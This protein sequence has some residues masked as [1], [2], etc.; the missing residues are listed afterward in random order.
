MAKTQIL[1]YYIH[2]RDPEVAA[3]LQAQLDAQ[4]GPGQLL[5]LPTGGVAIYRAPDGA[6]IEFAIADGS[7]P[8]ALSEVSVGSAVPATGGYITSPWFTSSN[9]FPRDVATFTRSSGWWLFGSTTRFY[10]AGHIVYDPPTASAG[11]D[12]GVEPTERENVRFG[13]QSRLFL[14]GFS[15]PPGG[16]VSGTTATG[17]GT[18]LQTTPGAGRTGQGYG[19]RC[20][21]GAGAVL[22]DTIGSAQ[23]G[24]GKT[25]LWQRIYIRPKTWGTATHIFWR[26]EQASVANTGFALGIALD[27][28]FAL[29][30]AESGS[31]NLVGTFGQTTIDAW[32]R[33]DIFQYIDQAGN[34]QYIDVD[35]NGVS[36]ISSSRAPAGVLGNRY[37][38][39]QTIGFHS[40]INTDHV[41]DLA[42][43]VGA[44]LPKTRDR[45]NA[46]WSAVTAYV[47]NDVVSY[48]GGVYAAKQ[49]GTNHTPGGA[50]NDYWQRLADPIDLANGSHLVR[51]TGSGFGAD[52]ANWTGA[53]QAL[54]QRPVSSQTSGLT[55]TTSGA[56]AHLVLD[57]TAKIDA[58]LGSIGWVAF[59][60]VL[61]SARGT[62]SGSL[63][64][65]IGA[66][67]EVT[68]A[69]TQNAALPAFNSVTATTA[70]AVP[71]KG[72]GLKL[73]HTKGADVGASTVAS[74]YAL[75]ECIG[76]FGPEDV[77]AWVSTTTYAVDEQV[78]YGGDIYVALA[79]STGAIPSSSPTSWELVSVPFHPDVSLQVHDWPVSPWA[80]TALPLGPVVI[81]GGTYVGNGTITT[82]SFKAPPTWIWIRATTGAS[83][84]GGRGWSGMLAPHLGAQQGA[85]NSIISDYRQNYAFAPGS[86]SDDQQMEFLV[87]IGGN[88]NVNGNAQTFQYVA[89][90][91]PAARFSRA[92]ATRVGSNIA[93]KTESLADPAFLPEVAFVAR[94]EVTATGTAGLYFKGSGHAASEAQVLNAGTP[95]AS[96]LTFGTGSLT[97]GTGLA[98]QNWSNFAA[99]GFRR[100]DGNNDA[101][102]GRVMFLGSYVGDNSA[103]RTIN[104]A[105]TSGRRPMW[106][107]V[108][109][110]N[111]PAHF[112]DPSHS[113]NSTTIAGATSATAITAGGI[114]S[115][116]V[117]LTLNA[118]GITY[119][120][121]GLP[122]S[123]TAGN[124]GWSIN[125]EEIPVASD[126]L[127]PSGWTE[128]VVIDPSTVT[129]PADT[130]DDP[131][132]LTTD[133]ATDC[134]NASTRL[135]NLALSRIGITKSLTSLS[136]DTSQEAASARMVYKTEIDATL[137]DFP[138][139]FATRYAT[140]TLVSGS[141]T[142]KTNNDWR[143]AYRAPTNS[144]F[145]RRLVN[146]DEA[147]DFS[148][149]PIPF[150]MGQDATGDLVYTD[151]PGELLAADTAIVAEY[152]LRLDCP[153]RYGDAIFRSAA[154]WRLAA[155]LVAPL[156]RDIKLVDY[157]E[158]R[159]QLE[160]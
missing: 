14:H 37:F 141:T 38:D 73:K 53:Y 13:F 142:A 83:I 155:A 120:Y 95:L 62:T 26:G 140:L 63:T 114:D 80:R 149:S 104:I 46:A 101:N 116:T 4:T 21:S 91:D 19:S 75:V 23:F 54:A 92:H 79:A 131:G 84:D 123:V 117:G 106:L 67:A 90:C 158:K 115:F 51:A 35:V 45:S 1:D 6:A 129:P 122:G 7:Y 96:A 130:N 22:R 59:K 50:T 156:A 89:F 87:D 30:K 42:D 99:I 110:T 135:T 109:P 2:L 34:V 136:T 64:Y 39:A 146:D 41:F 55:S 108:M 150:R 97:F 11:P 118:T 66:L 86:A 124:N 9:T 31:D 81:V 44:G 10:W 107:I 85:G 71:V 57:V 93:P 12:S 88:A 43:W 153:A 60:A 68:T 27:G 121:F 160:L 137:R 65:Q 98:N 32:S 76:S 111:A 17:G 147:R 28:K 112:R 49:N 138:W 20:T 25:K 8:P 18:L 133:I 102:Q 29:Y 100:A 72:T 143:Y 69:I 15:L 103:S 56:I 152:T 157:C 145:V 144:V 82:L 127:D 119:N 151:E 148:R 47:T 125:E 58:L 159:Y 128:P 154:A 16:E 139:P 33:L 134:V 77:Q 24:T 52:H 70:D 40:A 74:L 126:S 105:P 3:A 36:L 5:A 48:N 94:Q 78:S 61:A 113:G 132:E